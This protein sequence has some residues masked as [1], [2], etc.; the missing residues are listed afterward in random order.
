PPA[1]VGLGSCRSIATSA[2]ADVPETSPNRIYDV[3]LNTGIFSIEASARILKSLVEE[4]V[5]GE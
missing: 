2:S 5:S 1:V 3:I 4:Y